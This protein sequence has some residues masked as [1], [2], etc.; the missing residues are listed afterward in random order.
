MTVKKCSI[1]YLLQYSKLLDVAWR[2]IS[3][4]RTIMKIMAILC[5][6]VLF[7]FICLVL[8]TDGLPKETVYIVSTLWTFLT[9]ILNSV[10][11][12]RIGAR[13]GW[14]RLH[15]KRNASE[16][17]KK[18]DD[19]SPTGTIMRI[20]AIICNIVFL[21]FHYWAFVD[22]YPHPKEDGFI[23]FVV[24]MMLTPILSLMVLFRSGQWLVGSSHEKEGVS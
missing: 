20:V 5:N 18:T 17:Q 23:A 16:E 12:S 14:L 3:S 21:G 8:V 19:L 13:D 24:L 7:L 22:Q 10:V 9:L 4:R 6:I 11:I 2:K 1:Y 15:R